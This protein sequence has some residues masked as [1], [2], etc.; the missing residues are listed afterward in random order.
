MNEYLVIFTNIT[1]GFLALILLIFMLIFVSETESSKFGHTALASAAVG[2]S[3]FFLYK[4]LEIEPRA[5]L[6]LLGAAIALAL[7]LSMH[8][9]F[10]KLDKNKASNP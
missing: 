7:L 3:A 2:I 6:M 9:I 8:I 10:K 4:K 1:C 5:M